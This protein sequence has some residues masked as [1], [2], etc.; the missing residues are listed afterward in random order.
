MCG[1]VGVLGNHK[2]ASPRLVEALKRLEYRGYDS[3]GIATFTPSGVLERRRA[4]GKIHNL[5]ELL[6]GDPLPGTIGIGHTRWATHGAPSEVNA[7]PHGND[8]V[9]VV[10]NGIIE[11]HSDLR[12]ELQALGYTFESDTDTEVIVHLATHLLKEGLEPKTLMPRLL[13]RLH[14]AYALGMM[15][16]NW[17]G[18][19]IG[20]RKGSPLA[21]GYDALEGEMYL[22]SDS[23]ALIPFT[24]KISYLEEGDWVILSHGQAQVF[25][26]HNLPAV[27]P[28]VESSL[29][30]ASIG[31]QNHKHFMMKEIHEQPFAVA[32][33]LASI[34]NPG[35]HTV[36]L[37]DIPL[38]WR[39]I[40]RVTIVACGT[41]YLAGFVGKY[42]L[43][44]MARISTDVEI[45]SEF[46]YRTPPMMPGG[47]AIFVS[48]SG[49]TA[50]T[51][52]ALRY[53]KSQNQICL[54]I[55]NARESTLE[56]E[57]DY[58]IHTHG[59][60]EIGVAST[61]AFTTQLSVLACL[62]LEATTKRETQ[63]QEDIKRWS[64]SL[65]HLPTLITEALALEPQ[66]ARIAKGLAKARDVLFLGRGTSYPIALEG[67][68]KLKELSYIHAEGYAA[69]EL[70]HGPIALVDEKVPLVVLAPYDSV[71]E[72]TLSNLHE[73]VARGGQVILI[74]S[75]KG[76]E[77]L[78][79]P[80]ESIIMPENTESLLDPILYT[81]PLQLLAYYT[82]LEMGHDIDQP[83]NLAKSVTVE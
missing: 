75:Q 22:G 20:A 5:E 52:A 42:W 36:D 19:L 56:R 7:H 76:L 47:L 70:K 43:E 33:T 6:K 8:Q 1:I 49:E 66:V 40:P 83:R 30:L 31:K 78:K 61:K 65:T 58:V 34:L 10:H 55:V 4:E 24:N 26:H 73:A 48:Q 57:A 54:G 46:R 81:I 41:A 79:L 2:D 77:S 50:D 25:D 12:D 82:A 27:R 62:T 13:E 45:A 60:P 51:L 80:L 37:R 69:G 18:Q 67:A 9:A 72:K 15:F 68:L 3:A 39:E 71:F 32:E 14:G 74:T 29:S 35:N 44:S 38:N 17:P 28:I 21:I 23:M 59:G 53:A 64:Q 63:S 16:R 11:N